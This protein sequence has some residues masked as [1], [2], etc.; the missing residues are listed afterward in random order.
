MPT[1][2]LENDDD[3]AGEDNREDEDNHEDDDYSDV[4][5]CYS[6][7]SLDSPNWEPMETDES[8]VIT[9]EGIPIFIDYTHGSL[10]CTV[11]TSKPPINSEPSVAPEVSGS[12]VIVQGLVRADT[13]TATVTA[14]SVTAGSVTAGSVTAGLTF[15]YK[16]IILGLFLAVHRCKS[17]HQYNTERSRVINIELSRICPSWG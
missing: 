8:Y 1:L 14:G 4:E 6:D 3:V 9:S 16:F 10:F 5:S 2:P 11:S 7:I 13:T 12:N 17:N 15:S